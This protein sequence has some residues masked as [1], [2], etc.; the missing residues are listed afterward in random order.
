RAHRTRFYELEKV[1]R[2]SGGLALDQQY[3]VHG[4]QIGNHRLDRT[5]ANAEDAPLLRADGHR[6]TI[7]VNLAS[8]V[9]NPRPVFR[10]AQHRIAKESVDTESAAA[11]GEGKPVE[12]ALELER[13]FG[14]LALGQP[15]VQK[16]R[17]VGAGLQR[18]VAPYRRAVGPA[19]AGIKIDAAQT[20]F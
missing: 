3:L 17:D 12:I 10:I 5:D 9:V 18:H 15:L 4:F 16:R 20:F 6:R 2:R 14:D 19:Q 8:D 11:V 13:G 1:R 7:E